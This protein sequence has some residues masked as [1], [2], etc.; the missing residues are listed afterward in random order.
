MPKANALTTGKVFVW[1]IETTDFKA[2]F[3]HMLMWAGKFVGED[4]V[5][6]H[7]IDQQ[8]S[9][10]PKDPLTMIDDKEIVASAIEMLDSADVVVHH[11]GDKFDLPFLNTRALINNLLPP[12]PP[13]TIDTCKI[14]RNG[15][16]M[17]SNRLAALAETLAG[18]DEQ[19]QGLSK[20]QWKLAAIGHKKT[21]DAM[22]DYCIADVIATEAIYLRMRPI[23]RHHPFVGKSTHKDEGYDVC[24][25]CGGT[26][27]IKHGSRRTR[28]FEVFRRRCQACGNAYEAGRKKIA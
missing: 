18:E 3:G 26:H 14:A 9:W 13:S 8:E 12:L 20:D 19:K 21:L 22:L 17:T 4:T 5:Y 16:K 1:D 25:A 2:N 7:R 6:Y 10:N 11:Y 24:P 23:M 27:T 28:R 15:L